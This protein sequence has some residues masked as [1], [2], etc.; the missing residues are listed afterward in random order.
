MMER[1]SISMAIMVYDIN[2]YYNQYT[3][4]RK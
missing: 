3:F 4:R 1:I 2:M